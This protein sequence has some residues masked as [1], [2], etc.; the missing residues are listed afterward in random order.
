MSESAGTDET[1]ILL[2]RGFRLEWI[3]L[4]WNVVGVVVLA[5][6][7]ITASSVAIAGF[8]L[9]SL[10]EIGASV[11][12]VWELSGTG[13]ARQR[14]ALRLIG[15]A[16]VLLA[17][18]LTAQSAA[19]L[20]TAH[21]ASHSLGGIVWTAITAIVM[22]SLAAGKSRTGRALRNPVLIAE[23]RVTFV[24]GLLAVAVLVGLLL[25][26]TL[27]WWWAD[28]VVG[29]VIVYYAVREAVHSLATA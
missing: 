25:N 21:H 13:Q 19:A 28:P 11:V 22:F 12:V 23:G 9:D 3:T 10:I 6:L 29:F 1:A 27:G 17:I 15:V 20:I 18:Y 14:R 2:R 4:G 5:W 24:D 7:A 26:F 8:G 16:F